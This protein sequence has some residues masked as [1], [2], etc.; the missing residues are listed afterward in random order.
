MKRFLSRTSKSDNA[1]L[2]QE[3]QSLTGQDDT[4]SRTSSSL[5]PSKSNISHESYDSVRELRPMFGETKQLL[6]HKPS[7]AGFSIL[8]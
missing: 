6:L 2:N 5:K 8:D 4:K 3:T 1:D 7:E